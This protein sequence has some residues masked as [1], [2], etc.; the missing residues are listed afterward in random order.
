MSE[1]DVLIVFSGQG[2]LRG[3]TLRHAE[4]SLRLREVCQE[5]GGARGRHLESTIG[6]LLTDRPERAAEGL[7]AMA[8]DEIAFLVY[9]ASIAAYRHVGRAGWVPRALLGQS[10]GD[11]AALVCAGAF[12]VEQGAEIVAVRNQALRTLRADAGYMAMIG[13]GADTVRAMIAALGI[14]DL[15]IAV[16]NSSAET[17]V[18]GSRET[19]QRMLNAAV[20]R[21]IRFARIGAKYPIHC[22]PLMAG[23]VSA[24]TRGLEGVSAQPLRLPVFSAVLGRFLED[25][26]PLTEYLAGSL[27]RPVLFGE[28]LSRLGQTGITRSIDCSPLEGA[29]RYIGGV[30]GGGC[31]RAFGDPD[32]ADGLAELPAQR[33]LAKSA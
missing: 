5:I 22:A 10:F 9:G 27:A 1:T 7:N 30:F 13:A 11:I 3:E 33:M 6:E 12:S 31:R 25:R 21:G 16:E 17:V 14:S 32:R 20:G 18:A 29:S 8:S 4:I 19:I 15:A 26:D 24:M 28:A 23:A 2:T